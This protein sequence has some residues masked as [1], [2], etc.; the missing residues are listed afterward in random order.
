MSRQGRKVTIEEDI[1]HPSDYT[2]TYWGKPHVSYEKSLTFKTLKEAVKDAMSYLAKGEQKYKCTDQAEPCS[3]V[4]VG[5]RVTVKDGSW[6]LELTEGFL[7]PRRTLMGYDWRV[8]AVGQTLPTE[9]DIPE[10]ISK[11]DTIIYDRESG[12]TIFIRHH[13]LD[14]KGAQFITCQNCGTKVRI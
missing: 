8:K 14:V 11:N 13:Y 7:L 1:W 10:H 3:W 2:V 4:K 9:A 5:D 6:A 12:R